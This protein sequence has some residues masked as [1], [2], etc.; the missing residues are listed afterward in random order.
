MEFATDGENLGK[1]GAFN[2]GEIKPGVKR[3][4][5]FSSLETLME[6]DRLAEQPED[7]KVW[8]V[9]SG[10]RLD[11]YT[12]FNSLGDVEVKLSLEGNEVHT[13]EHELKADAGFAGWITYVDQWVKG[14]SFQWEVPLEELPLPA[15][16]LASVIAAGPAAG[17][18]T[19]QAAGNALLS[20]AVLTTE[21]NVPLAP[22][23]VAVTLGAPVAD[24]SELGNLSAV[25]VLPLSALNFQPALTLDPGGLYWLAGGVLRPL[26][27]EQLEALLPQAGGVSLVAAAPDANVGNDGNPNAGA[28]NGEPADNSNA[29]KLHNLARACLIPIFNVI[30][31]V[32]GME[33]VAR[34]LF[35]GAKAGLQ[36]DYVLCLLLKHHG[37]KAKQWAVEAAGSELNKWRTDPKKRAE[38]FKEL[39]RH[40]CEEMIFNPMQK[41]GG[42]LADGFSSWDKFKEKAWRFMERFARAHTTLVDSQARMFALARDTSG[43]HMADGLT[44]WADDFNR[45]M[46]VQS[47]YSAF[48]DA[49]WRKDELLNDMIGARRERAYTFGYIEGYLVE[50]VFLGGIVV[51]TTL[52][53]GKVIARGGASIT[54]GLVLSL[55]ASFNISARMNLL[56]KWL[57]GAVASAE[58][59]LAIER[60]FTLASR[61]P[62]APGSKDLVID[63]VESSYTRA[64]YQ[65]AAFG[66]S[67]TLDEVLK[68]PNILQAMQTAGNEQRFWHVHAICLQIMGEQGTANA[69]KGFVRANNRV[70][71][72]A[73]DKLIE[74]RTGDLFFA[75]KVDTTEG[76]TVLR[77]SLEGFAARTQS[78]VGTELFK[79]SPKIAEIYPS[80]YHYKR[81]AAFADMPSPTKIRAPEAGNVHYLTPYETSSSVEAVSRLQLLSRS[82]PTLESLAERAR[83]RFKIKTGSIK[84]DINVPYG[85]DYSNGSWM[86]RLEP[87][88][89]EHPGPNHI[90]GA[91]QFTSSSEMVVEEVFDTTLGRVLTTPE[92][93]Q[94][95]DA[96][97]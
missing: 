24:I 51:G 70:L 73:D 16:T 2:G 41:A 82:T 28:G 13:L 86:E 18:M 43:T 83:Y 85:Y 27:Q 9:R 47:E 63:I 17:G 71:K 46:M 48:A 11:W 21:T 64:G 50:Q 33:A 76:A 95:I 91:I 44:S 89:R 92:I 78:A 55:K 58:L 32:E 8:F 52:K 61:T 26:A 72:F 56:K 54:K 3:A 4:T 30:A 49:P 15:Q 67:H 68:A 20:G 1:Y 57:A 10:E 22:D 65:R 6:A 74:D 25:R 39:A 77:E 81:A 59:R 84:N 29:A 31:Q 90:G 5:V 75:L 80:L 37:L 96:A 34:G 19:A 97:H 35:D 40:F 36:D 42:K 7:Q 62:I 94:L 53:L 93:Q 45:R 66:I 14:K 88:C 69:A 12:C 60:G 87:I 23:P 79:V 38:E